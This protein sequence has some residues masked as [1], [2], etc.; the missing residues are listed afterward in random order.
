MLV[1]TRDFQPRAEVV[2]GL[3]VTLDGHR[4]AID[5]YHLYSGLETKLDPGIPLVYLGCGMM[6]LGLALLPFR[7]CEAWIRHDAEGW[8]IGGRV[9]RGRVVLQREL[10]QL[11]A[12]WNRCGAPEP[13][14]NLTGGSAS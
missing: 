6:L 9:H 14:A 8:L 12:V 5:S 7:H 13:A 3:P 10:A 2:P 4:F 1:D 11:A